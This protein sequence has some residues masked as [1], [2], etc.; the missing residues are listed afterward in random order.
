MPGTQDLLLFVPLGLFIGLGAGVAGYS[1][2]PMLVPLLFVVR[3]EAI[4]QAILASMLVDVGTAATLCVLYTRHGNVDLRVASRLAPL[5]A[6]AAIPG[7]VVSLLY[8]DQMGGLLESVS[9]IITVGIGALFVRRGLAAG[10]PSQPARDGGSERLLH[11]GVGGVG[12]L[13]GLIGMGGGFSIAALLVFVR[14]M[15]AA[16]SVGTALFVTALVLSMVSLIC[17]FSV[18]FEVS[19]GDVIVPVLVASMVGA[20]LGATYA[21]RIGERRLQ[22]SIGVVVI[23][24]GTAATIQMLGVR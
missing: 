21:Q 20:L 6:A 9:G 17:L 8:L 3:G 5:A 4:D 13:M 14:G 7:C 16:R 2:W 15:T 12:L 22:L 18:H 23:I 11:A 19:S 24:A 10:A 1:A